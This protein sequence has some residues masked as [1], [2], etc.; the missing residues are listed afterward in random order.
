MK[1]RKVN[2]ISVQDWDN[3]VQSVYGRPY[4]LQ[5]Q[6]GCK[7]RGIEEVT[8]P[9]SID[10]IA[11][12]DD[13][14]TEDKEDVNYGINFPTAVSLPRWLERDP[15]KPLK[16][17]EYDWQLSLWWDRNFYPRLDDIAQDLYNKGHLEAGDYTI[18][19]DW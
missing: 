19:I 8:V 12:E 11:N 1:I 17:Q 5:Q 16:N 10:P 13:G 14:W 2:M 15:S 18:A 9:I 6:D 7:S 3:L 4:S